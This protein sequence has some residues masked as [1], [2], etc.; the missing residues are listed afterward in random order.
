[1][2]LMIAIKYCQIKNDGWVFHP[3]KLSVDMGVTKDA[4][5]SALLSSGERLLSKLGF[6]QEKTTHCFRECVFQA[7]PRWLP[8]FRYE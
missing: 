2:A 8:P 3:S 1:M 4:G 6:D 5:L 7:G